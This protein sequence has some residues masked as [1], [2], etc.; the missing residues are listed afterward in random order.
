MN[1]LYCKLMPEIF[2]QV[3]L[4]TCVIVLVAIGIQNLNPLPDYAYPGF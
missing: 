1:D 2:L 4:L 3:F